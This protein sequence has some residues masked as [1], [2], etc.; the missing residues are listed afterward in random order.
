LI[1]T[2]DF[3]EETYVLLMQRGV[4]YSGGKVCSFQAEKTVLKEVVSKEIKTD[5]DK[6][7]NILI[8]G[9]N[10]HALSVLSV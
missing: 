8:E 1:D 4:Q 5:P 6:P 3:Q 10:Y 7:T 2:Y 9:D